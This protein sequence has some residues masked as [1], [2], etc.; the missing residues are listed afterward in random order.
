MYPLVDHVA[1]KVCALFETHERASGLMQPSTRFRDLADLAIFANTIS[2]GATELGVA[3][4]SEAKRR[5][6]LAR[7]SHGA[8]RSGLGKRLHAGRTRRA[9][10]KE[11]D[12]AS[13]VETVGC[14]IDPALAGIARGQWDPTTLRWQDD[15][16]AAP[17]ARV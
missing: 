6:D 15:L 13:A 1:D 9:S 8:H 11:R 7:P 10:L 12:L 16:A 17:E 14:F 2:V 4:A 3:L 5:P